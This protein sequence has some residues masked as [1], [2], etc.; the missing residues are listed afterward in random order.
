VVSAL[1]ERARAAAASVVDPELPMLTL[2]DLGVLRDVRVE[3]ER[4]VVTIT[5]T[6]TGCPAMDTMRADLQ[7]A[8]RRAGVEDAEVRTALAPAWS[9]DDISVEGR[10]KLAEH[11]IAPPGPRTAG[12]VPLALGRAP[13]GVPCPQCGAG[14]TRELSHFGSTACKAIRTCLAC[15]E[16][17]DHVKAH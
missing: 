2:A 13:T 14:E 9:T 11:G 8:L 12:P 16:T 6:Y 4:V 1:L 5:P 15:G 3:G 10:R 17:F 7:V